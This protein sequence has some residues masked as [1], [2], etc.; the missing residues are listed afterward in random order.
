MASTVIQEAFDAAI[1][2]LTN[3]ITASITAVNA[4]IATI[5]TRFFGCTPKKSFILQ[6]HDSEDEDIQE[7]HQ[8][9]IWIEDKRLKSS[10]NPYSS[11][12]EYKLKADIPSFNGSFRIE[13][14]LDWF[15]EVEA[16]FQFMEI[17]DHSKVRL[18]AYKLK[19]GVAAW[20]ERL[21]DERVNTSK[22]P[23]RT[24]DRMHK[25]LRGFPATTRLQHCRQGARLVEEY[26]A[27][28]YNLLA[29]NE[30]HESEEQ[31]VARFVEGLNTLIQQ[32]MVQS[33]FTMVDAIQQA[34]EIERRLLRLAK[35]SQ[36]RQSRYQGNYKPNTSYPNFSQE[37]TP[38]YYS[39]YSYQDDSSHA[40]RKPTYTTLYTPPHLNTA[41]ILPTP[42]KIQAVQQTQVQQNR[43]ADKCNKW[44]QP[45]HTSSE[46]RKINAFIGD[47]Q[48]INEVN[49]DFNE[50]DEEDSPET[51]DEDEFVGMIR[52]LLLTQPCP[53]QRHNIFRSKCYIGGKFCNMIIDG[54]S[55][56][57]YVA[58]H[59]V[60]KLGLPVHPHPV[61]YFVGWVN[62][63]TTQD[64]TH[65]CYVTFKFDGYEDSVLCDVID[66]TATH[67][68][69]GRP[70]KY[71]IQ[72]LIPNQAHYRLS[73]TEHEIL[74]GQ[75]NDLIQKG[76]IR[77]S[78]SPCARPGFLVSK[79]DG[80]W[81]MCIDCRALNRITIPYRFPIPRIDDMIKFLSGSIIFTKLDLRSGYHQIRIREGDEWKTSFKTR[82]G[83]YE[84]LFMPFGLSNAPSTF[85]RLMNQ[86]LQPFLSKFVIV[87]FDD[88]LI[89]SRNE[90]EHLDHL[91]QVFQVLVDNYLYVNLKKRFVKNFS[92]IFAPLTDCLKKEKF[93]WT[94][95]MDISFNALKEKLYTAPILVLPNFE[96][97]FEIDC[98][99]SIVGIDAVL[100]QE[101]H[102]IA[103]HSENNSDAQ[104]KWSTY[105]LELLALVQ[106]LKQWH[107]YLIHRE[108]VVNTDN[109]ALKFLN[110]SA[111]VNRMHDRWL[112]TINNIP[113]L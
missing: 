42:I 13:E 76:L 108:F 50:L 54:G 36:P 27:E 53:S 98:D 65:Q 48:F 16:F 38:M 85:M 41:L 96:K 2:K 81:R 72:A 78:N 19:G 80:G 32:G 33:V 26:V 106:A 61:P 55:V 24:W 23:I 31:L 39:K 83:L 112:A 45:G 34:I 62:K 11:L 6:I 47:T 57:N 92:S 97:P 22:P 14:L 75:V 73:P 79:K 67:L 8:E 25:L 21:C 30:L 7:R 68:L 3:L 95:A 100:S 63:S 87:Y 110:T 86:V 15:Y 17:P 40:Y 44:L 99:A 12:P 74:Q 84:W 113:S 59:V 51:Q 71:D 56:D 109:H 46:C 107:A 1:T 104:K 103:Y 37:V 77:P 70:W 90:Q 28:F 10:Q 111:K 9:K 60:K 52:P 88:I 64:I 29:R 93:E 18:V 101:G 20:W 89:F 49:D 102:P 82:E 43:V 94:E 58:A 105:E 35:I 5:N 66:L 91:S 69:L 4:G